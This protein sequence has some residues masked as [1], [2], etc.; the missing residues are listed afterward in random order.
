MFAFWYLA[1]DGH[2]TLRFS[3]SHQARIRPPKAVDGLCVEL[4]LSGVSV[5]FVL[6]LV[7]VLIVVFVLVLSLLGFCILNAA[8]SM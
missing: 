8:L 6:A 1:L 2:K 3:I 5:L 7:F 4:S